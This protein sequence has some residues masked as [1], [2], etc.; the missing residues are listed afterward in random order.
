MRRIFTTIVW[1]FRDWLGIYTP[2]QCQRGKCACPNAAWCHFPRCGNCDA[3]LDGNGE[4]F[5]TGKFIEDWN[6]CPDCTG[7]LQPL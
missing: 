5:D 4:A 7:A 3:P 2:G 6:R 1:A